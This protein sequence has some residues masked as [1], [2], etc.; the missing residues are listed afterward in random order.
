ML[1]NLKKIFKQ[2][3]IFKILLVLIIFGLFFSIFSFIFLSK[4]KLILTLIVLTVFIISFK[5]I[6]L[7][8]Y[9]VAFLTPLIIRDRFNIWTA[10]FSVSELVLLVVLFNWILFILI[11][12]KFKFKKTKLDLP[13]LIF[14]MLT[15]ISFLISLRYINAPLEFATSASNLYPVKVLLNTFEYLLFFYLIINVLAKKDI[16]KVI[17]ISLTSLLTVSLFG[18]Y[19]YNRV[20]SLTHFLGFENYIRVTSTLDIDN[21][22]G[23]YLI[24]FIPLVFY[25]VKKYH[26]QILIGF[27]AL[28]CLF[29]SG[30][31]GAFYSFFGSL[32][33]TFRKN[34]RN[35]ILVCVV[36]ILLISTFFI[37]LSKNNLVVNRIYNLDDDGRIDLFKIS[38]TA[39]M[40]NPMGIGLG[41]FRLNGIFGN[42]HHS[43]NIYFQIALERGIL[44]LIAFLWILFIFFKENITT[45]I[46]NYRLS[47]I[48]LAL[49]TGI[50]AILLYGLVD[51]PFYNQRI[52]VLFWM[53]IGL[54]IVINQR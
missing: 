27:P 29:Y 14:T 15:A 44:A 20:F 38:L 36:A 3:Y 17:Y 41:A 54:V 49:V 39:I 32:L 37:L 52:A 16:K 4:S 5:R 1:N 45:K 7:G 51:Y 48:R 34:K 25:F 53:V 24:L 23:M 9:L 47:N 6:K 2:K 10:N 21:F 28:L 12:K 13:I 31:R 11:N 42:Y 40:K 22:L 50:I 19:Q 18:V 30:S 8:V 46:K 43:H 26:H 33:I 35:I